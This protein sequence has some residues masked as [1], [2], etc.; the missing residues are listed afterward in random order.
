MD[1]SHSDIGYVNM[2]FQ[3]SIVQGHILFVY[4]QRQYYL[5]NLN[6]FEK[7]I[8]NLYMLKFPPGEP[9]NFK[10]LTLFFGAHEI[11]VFRNTYWYNY[12]FVFLFL[13]KFLTS[14]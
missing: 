14:C 7:Q 13:F 9:G 3:R 10:Q 2:F 6:A 11:K 5:H 1:N 8:N 4:S 12:S